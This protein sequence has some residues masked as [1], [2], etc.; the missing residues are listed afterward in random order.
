MEKKL[1]EAHGVEPWTYRTAA[2]CS[3]TELYLH[4]CIK[5]KIAPNRTNTKIMCWCETGSRCGLYLGFFNHF[6]DILSQ[7]SP[8]H[9]IPSWYLP[10]IDNKDCSWHI[11]S[12]PSQKLFSGELSGAV[13]LRE[14]QHRQ[15]HTGSGKTLGTILRDPIVPGSVGQVRLS[16]YSAFFSFQSAR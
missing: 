10:F 9:K 3:T 8:W 11:L 4:N 15:Y 13:S 12:L 14:G 5:G 16:G 2:D 7:E 1:K 6:Q